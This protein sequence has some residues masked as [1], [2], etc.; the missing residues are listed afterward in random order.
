MEENNVLF[1]WEEDKRKYSNRE[2][3]IYFTLHMLTCP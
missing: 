1:Y 2:F 3:I